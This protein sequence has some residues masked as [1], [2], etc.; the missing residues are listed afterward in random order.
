[1][2]TDLQTALDMLLREL[3]QAGAR[4]QDARARANTAEAAVNELR[5]R[6]QADE[7]RIVPAAA[8]LQKRLDT[9]RTEV[10]A[11][12]GRLDADLQAL[13]AQVAERTR[14]TEDRVRR[15]LEAVRDMRTNLQKLQEELQ[16]ES[17]RTEAALAAAT[18]RSAEALA[19]ARNGMVAL[20]DFVRT[21]FV[22]RLADHE[23]AMEAEGQR[24]TATVRERFLPTVE[25]RVSELQK[26]LGQAAQE[27]RRR[28]AEHGADAR[29]R[30]DEALT[31][32][33]TVTRQAGEELGGRASESAAELAQATQFVGERLHAEEKE[34]VALLQALSTAGPHLKDLEG[35]PIRLQTTLRKARVI[36]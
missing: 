30:T 36:P 17:A 33:E 13:Q 2:A 31:A 5:Q 3:N 12:H 15:M 28:A 34:E 10:E 7:A 24:L 9:G 25:A 22:P 8:A 29:T 16:A 1:M 26:L 14:A 21:D 32:L 6:V 18:E 27:I 4:M 20:D 23:R 19:A 11:A 35:I